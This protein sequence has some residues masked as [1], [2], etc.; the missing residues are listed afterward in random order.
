MARAPSASPVKECR[1]LRPPAAPCYARSV[2]L[3][4]AVRVIRLI[5]GSDPWGDGSPAPGPVS[6]KMTLRPGLDIRGRVE[7]VPP[8]QLHRKT[9]GSAADG[10]FRAAVRG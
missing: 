6:L 9:P 1:S 8:P 7:P 4:P 2:C 5:R 3:S 10:R